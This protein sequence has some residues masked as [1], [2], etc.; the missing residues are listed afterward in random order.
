MDISHEALIRAWP[1]VREW[2]D[3][4]RAGQRVLR[5]ITES[6]AEWVRLA[7]DEGLLFRGARLAEAVEWREEHEALLND[8]ERA[9]LDASACAPGARAG[10]EGAGPAPRDRGGRRPGRGVPGAR[11][12]RRAASG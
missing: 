8:D 1:R 4:D 6:S 9:F 5:R 11:R 2:L 10:G 12:A 3:E 7:R